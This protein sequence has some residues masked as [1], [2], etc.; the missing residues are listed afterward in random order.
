M[1]EHLPPPTMDLPAP[2]PE[3]GQTP[4]EGLPG[5]TDISEATLAQTAEQPGTAMTQNPFANPGATTIPP[6]IAP[7]PALQVPLAN[8]PADPVMADDGDLIEKEWVLK[9]KH[10]VDKT[11]DDPHEQNKAVNR[12]KADYMKQRYHKDLK[13]SDE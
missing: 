12:V 3:L 8:A 6:P 7:D 4:V 11:K 13:L 1:D 9:A 5:G 10:I 2:H